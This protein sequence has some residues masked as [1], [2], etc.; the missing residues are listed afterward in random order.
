MSEAKEGDG[1]VRRYVE[2]RANISALCQ[3]MIRRLEREGSAAYLHGLHRGGHSM[4]SRAR[5]GW[6]RGVSCSG[7]RSFA[8][9]RCWRETL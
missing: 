1:L 4:Y 8:A 5:T 6:P 9:A 2:M 3:R 7:G